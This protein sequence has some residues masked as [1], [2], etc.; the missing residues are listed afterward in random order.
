[1]S[2]GRLAPC[3]DE[4]VLMKEGL[5]PLS[6]KFVVNYMKSRSLEIPYEQKSNTVSLASKSATYSPGISFEFPVYSLDSDMKNKS[7]PKSDEMP[8]SAE[9]MLLGYDCM[10][11]L[12]R[13]ANLET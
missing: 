9:G 3:E 6:I 2:I 12:Q 7:H 13:E 4:M 8:T 5:Y 11:I 10:A 1:M